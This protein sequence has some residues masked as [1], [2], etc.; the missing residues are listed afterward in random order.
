MRNKKPRKQSAEMVWP[1]GT[2]NDG[3]ITEMRVALVTASN[4]KNKKKKKREPIYPWETH[5]RMQSIMQDRGLEGE[6]RRNDCG[7]SS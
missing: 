2:N 1:C 7:N 3:K 4:S 6:G 5:R